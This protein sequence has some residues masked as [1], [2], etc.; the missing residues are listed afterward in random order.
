ME[1]TDSL[2]MC[3]MFVDF[4]IKFFLGLIVVDLT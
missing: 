2:K 4:L 1:G 3:L